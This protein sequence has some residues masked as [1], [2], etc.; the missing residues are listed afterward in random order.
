VAV[1]IN[2]DRILKF[3]GLPERA[4]ETVLMLLSVVLVSIVGLTPGQSADALG[5]ELLALGLGFGIVTVRLA[6]RSLPGGSQPRSWLISR[7]LVATAATLPLIV[8]GASLLAEAGGG[9]YW[10]VAGIIFAIAGAVANAWV[11]LIEILR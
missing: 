9:L 8:G 11:L 2:V 4:L 6:R 5:A 3:E 1:S 10:V 7:V